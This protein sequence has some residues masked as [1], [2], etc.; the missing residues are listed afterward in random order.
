MEALPLSAAALRRVNVS[1][2]P[3]I[4]QADLVAWIG[5]AFTRLHTLQAAESA[6]SFDSLMQLADDTGSAGSAADGNTTFD[7]AMQQLDLSWCDAMEDVCLSPLLRLMPHLRHLTLRTQHFSDDMC[8]TLAEHCPLLEHLTVAR[9]CGPTASDAGLHV[10]SEGCPRLKYV[11]ISWNND[12]T[13]A[14]VHSLLAT[15]AALE[16]L[17]LEGVKQLTDKGL[18]GALAAAPRGALRCLDLSWVNT[19]D[20]ALVQLIHAHYPYLEVVDYYTN[21]HAPPSP[22]PSIVLADPFTKTLAARA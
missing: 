14:G 21:S 7:L 15:C 17:V 16:H 13:D 20:T 12:V 19:C 2:L 4:P 5:P 11:N 8:Q 1:C 9:A 18:M 6:L 3:F 22:V 10:L